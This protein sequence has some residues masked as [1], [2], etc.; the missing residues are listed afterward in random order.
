M[1]I[2]RS[3]GLLGRSG[4]LSLVLALSYRM[5][6]WTTGICV[7]ICFIALVIICCLCLQKS[8]VAV[9]K[10]Q[11]LNDAR[12]RKWMRLWSHAQLSMSA[13]R[14]SPTTA[15]GFCPWSSVGDRQSVRWIRRGQGGCALNVASITLISV[16]VVSIPVNAHQSL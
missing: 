13:S 9:Y 6:A 7:I 16:A 5:S 11:V 4:L 12:Q 15:P 8:V 3:I 10:I 2:I 14:I 1:V